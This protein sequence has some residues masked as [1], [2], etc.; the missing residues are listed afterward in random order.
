MNEN[1]WNWENWFANVREK[2]ELDDMLEYLVQMLKD[3]D[4]N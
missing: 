2:S 1:F 4:H 3:Y